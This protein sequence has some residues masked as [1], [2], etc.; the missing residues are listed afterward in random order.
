MWH[1]PRMPHLPQVREVSALLDLPQSTVSII[2]E[3]RKHLWGTTSQSKKVFRTAS[4]SDISTRI[5]RW[6]LHEMG[7][8]LHTSQRSLY[9]MLSVCLSSV[10][11]VATGLWSKNGLSEV[12]IH[13]SL[14]G[15]LTDKSRFW[16]MP[17]A[18]YLPECVVPTVKLGG[19][20]IMGWGCFSVF[21]PLSSTEG[22]C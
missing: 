2:I 18:H 21:G 15:C 17:G 7:F 4:G 8:Q 3:K 19:G 6:E 10:K 14:S 9:A 5:V 20:G 1:W 13:T 16:L 12:M 22:W 11:Y